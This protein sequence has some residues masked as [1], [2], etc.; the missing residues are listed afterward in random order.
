MTKSEPI[1]FK[2]FAKL[3]RDGN[4]YFKA[5]MEQPPPGSTEKREITDEQIHGLYESYLREGGWRL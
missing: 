2:E 1:S 4:G 5:L 3:F